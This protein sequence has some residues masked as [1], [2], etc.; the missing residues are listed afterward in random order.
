MK[1]YIFLS[2][3]GTTYAP[4]NI[5]T[6]EAAEIENC[7]MLGKAQGKDQQQAKQNL[8][9]E[10]SWIDETGFDPEEIFGYELAK[11]TK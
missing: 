3:E 1:Q 6:D 9:K 4:W 8:L 11:E 2:C 5:N 7:Q 10:N